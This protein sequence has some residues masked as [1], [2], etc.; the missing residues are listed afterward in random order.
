MSPPRRKK[1]KHLPKRV[2]FKT[3]CYY[4]VDIQ[5]KWHKLGKT[6]A[7]AMQTWSQMFEQRIFSNKTMSAV[8]DR[9]IQEVSTT[10]SES[11][12]KNELSSFKYLRAFFGDM[13]P[14]D[15]TPVDVYRHL[16]L[17][18]RISKV[19]ANKELSLM[20]SV[21]A[22]AIRWGIVSEN[23]CRDIKRFKE[24]TRD[25]YVQ[26]EEFET[27]YNYADD[28]IK[29]FMLVSYLT[30]LRLGDVLNV[31]FGD[32]T[33]EGILIVANKTKKKSIIVWTDALRDAVD[34]AKKLKRPVRGFY[35][36]C[37]RDGK[38]YSSDGFKA[39]WQRKMK[40]AH[41]NGVLK[42]RFMIKDLR[43]KAATD[44]E[45]NRGLEFAQALLGHS[46]AST[47]RRHYI[48]KVQKV[49]PVR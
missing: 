4:F 21:F 39:I 19:Q 28:L 5:N 37:T 32:L 34:F 25:R 44:I 11:T 10:K 48:R 47:T 13:S 36:F 2:Y 29:A 23:I 30:G 40:K 26:D 27:F 12:Y 49:N 18:A 31:K 22:S 24:P 6:L 15:I 8:F 1:D 41:E 38:P 7:E 20:S 43:A 16:D 46:N 3:G 42:E 45:Q 9:Y 33:E 17:R 35:L 14:Q